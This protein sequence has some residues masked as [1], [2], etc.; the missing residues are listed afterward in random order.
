VRFGA[1]VEQR[2]G[3]VLAVEPDDS[4]T[5]PEVASGELII[6]ADELGAAPE[7]WRIGTSADL[8]VGSPD[9]PDAQ[10]PNLEIASFG[11]AAALLARP[12]VKR[13][14]SRWSLPEITPPSA[15]ERTWIG[16]VTIA[17]ISS[18]LRSC[19][20]EALKSRSIRVRPCEKLTVPDPS[21]DPPPGVWPPSLL[22]TSRDPEKRPSVTS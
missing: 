5:E 22:N 12:N 3:R 11:T 14:L 10:P 21:I 19:A 6:A 18:R 20:R 1:D 16:P 13:P 8:E 9:T 17:A 15:L 2:I 7:R 4:M